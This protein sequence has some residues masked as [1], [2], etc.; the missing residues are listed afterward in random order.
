MTK[1][2]DAID[3]MITNS[4]EEFRRAKV[5]PERC[6]E[7]PHYLLLERLGLVYPAEWQQVVSRYEW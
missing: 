3:T 1:L 2:D 4:V 5:D 6:R 7:N